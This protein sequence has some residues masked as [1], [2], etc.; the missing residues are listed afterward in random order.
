VLKKLEDDRDE[1]IK[2]ADKRLEQAKEE[3][4]EVSK[5]KEQQILEFEEVTKECDAASARLLSDYQD[6]SARRQAIG[7]R[8]RRLENS[9]ADVVLACN[10]EL[11]DLKLH[12]MTIKH[13][14]VEKISECKRARSEMYKRE[15][16]DKAAEEAEIVTRE[17]LKADSGDMGKVMR[18]SMKFDDKKFAALRKRRAPK[19]KFAAR[20]R[21]VVGARVVRPKLELDDEEKQGK[22]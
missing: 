9:R 16:R 12:L 18:S 22:E 10:K 1:L 15:A 14:L 20:P 8:K 2:Q 13:Q 5:Q 3:Y 4:A 6:L 7:G 21:T 11:D 17:L 19:K